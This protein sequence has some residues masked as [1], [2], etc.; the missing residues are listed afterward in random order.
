MIMIHGLVQLL[1]FKIDVAPSMKSK[2]HIESMKDEE[3]NMH[4]HYTVF[5]A[6]DIERKKILFYPYSICGC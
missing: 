4:D 3:E 5:L 6:L 1:L 2:V